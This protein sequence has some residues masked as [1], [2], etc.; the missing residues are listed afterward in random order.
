MKITIEHHNSTYT[1]CTSAITVEEAVTQFKGLLV[2]S[3]FHPESVDHCFTIGDEW[4]P[5][6]SE[7]EYNVAGFEPQPLLTKHGEN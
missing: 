3:G 1:S 6:D 5:D 2:A 7:V 4:F